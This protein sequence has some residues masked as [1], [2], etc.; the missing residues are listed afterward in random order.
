MKAFYCRQLSR[1]RA[2]KKNEKI[3]LF[4]RLFEHTQTLLKCGFARQDFMICEQNPIIV[5]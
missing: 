5:L 2:Q 1:F 3:S 4:L